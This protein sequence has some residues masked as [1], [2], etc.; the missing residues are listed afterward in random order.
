MRLANQLKIFTKALKLDL[1]KKNQSNSDAYG[2]CLT[3][4]EAIDAYCYFRHYT[5]L[6]LDKRREKVF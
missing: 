2:H 1:Q 5:E 6:F 3:Y 4:G